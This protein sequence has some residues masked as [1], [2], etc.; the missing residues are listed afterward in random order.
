MPIYASPIFGPVRSRR[1][2]LSLGLNLLPADGKVCSFDCIY[3]ECGLNADHRPQLPMPTREEVRAGLREVLSDIGPQLNV[4]T[5]AGNGEPTLHPQ[6]P[7]IMDDVVALRNS[8]APQ[9]KV[10]VLSNATTATRPAVRRALMKADNPIMKLDTADPA[11]I[12]RVDQP[13]GRY[14]V[15]RIVEALAAMEGQC[16]VQTMFMRGT[17]NGQ[18]V[19]N[20]GQAYVEPWLR[21]V[22]R[23]APK[24]VMIYT[25]DRQTP[26][27]TLQKASPEDLEAIAK[28]VRERGLSCQVSS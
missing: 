27:Q 11:Y 15:G 26:V 24:Q 16:I 23:I 17:H 28:Q 18:D 2:G 19:S 22:E 5:F 14:D 25:I 1:L 12:G 20:V 21:A 10:S 4:I 13:V 7:Q 8:Y 3:C 9:A 6:F